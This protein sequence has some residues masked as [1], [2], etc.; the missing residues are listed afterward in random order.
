MGKLNWQYLAGFFDGEGT[1]YLSRCNKKRPNAHTFAF[2]IKPTIS[3]CNTKKD[4]LIAIK[5][6]L[7]SEEIKTAGPYEN[8]GTF[9]IGVYS[10]DSAQ[11]F[12]ER[13]IGYSILK[14]NQL[15]ILSKAI[16]LHEEIKQ[17]RQRA[18]GLKEYYGYFE[19]LSREISSFNG[20]Q[21]IGS[22]TLLNA[23]EPYWLSKI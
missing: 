18:K 2:G 17:G 15:E 16:K 22:R 12:I 21:G 3:I 1:V 20:A 13:I 23:I 19:K 14:H 9:T 4:L 5:N 8:R 7:L 10:W 6:F 11:R